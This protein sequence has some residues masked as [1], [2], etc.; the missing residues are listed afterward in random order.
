MGG[1]DDAESGP[2]SRSYLPGGTLWLLHGKARDVSLGFLSLFFGPGKMT[3]GAVI[4][5]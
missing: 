3:V 5:P 4:F 1:T 2:G